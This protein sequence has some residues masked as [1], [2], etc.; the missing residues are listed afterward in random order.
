MLR[1]KNVFLVFFKNYEWV[2]K[3]LADKLN[4]SPKVR[5]PEGFDSW[6]KSSKMY[7]N[8][9]LKENPKN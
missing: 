2:K 1:L 8:V 7:G 9:S 5:D 3:I 4:L 6:K